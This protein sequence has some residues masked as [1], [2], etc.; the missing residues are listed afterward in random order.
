[1]NP[2]VV[3]CQEIRTNEEI[4]VLEGYYHYWNHAQKPKYSGTLIMTKEEPL[5]VITG[6]STFFPD[7]EGRVISVE[8]PKYYIVNIYAPMSA[9][10][11]ER[12]QY[13]L[14][15]DEAL[16]DF[17][18]DLAE[19]KPIIMCGDFNVAR[20]DIDIYPENLHQYWER[21]GYTSDEADDLESLLEDG[22]SDAFR[23]LYP[24]LEGA[25]T[26][27]SNRRNRRAAERGW[28][29]DYFFLSNSL[30]P[31]LT[32]VIHHTDIIGSDHCPIEL[33]LK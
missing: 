13:R 12:K 5:S 18:S 23:Y 25:Y 30:L 32:D 8:L 17:I 3:C 20:L 19:S 21:Q 29:L 26:W 2:D 4:T 27:W 1:M 15:W 6:L 16:R 9:K 22:Y 11:L 31:K 10:K 7:T 33:V 14:E 28:R 24:T